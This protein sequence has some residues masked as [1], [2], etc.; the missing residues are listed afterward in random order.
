MQLLQDVR[1]LSAILAV[2]AFTAGTMGCGEA[3]APEDLAGT[4]SLTEV[5]GEPPPQVV[6]STQSTSG[7]TTTTRTLEVV[8]GSVSVSSDGSVD[9]SVTGRLTTETDG[10]TDSNSNND[11]VTAT[12]DGGDLIFSA[13]SLNV[14]TYSFGITDSDV[15]RS[16]IT[17]RLER[18]STPFDGSVR[19]RFER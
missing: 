17:V 6:D 9:V 15:S 5:N 12:F 16:T 14:E 13:D 7:G 2:L 4:F 3:L 1:P 19:L 10:S 8:D 11:V 18:T